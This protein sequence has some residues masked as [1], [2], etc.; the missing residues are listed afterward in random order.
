MLLAGWIWCLAGHLL[1]RG[2]AVTLPRVAGICPNEVNPNLWVDAMSTCTRECQSDQECESLEKCCAN[3]C[4]SRSCVA[5]RYADSAGARGPSGEPKGGTCD[6]LKCAQQGSQCEVWDGQPAC[7]CQERC[8]REPSFTCASDGMTYYNRCYMDAEACSKGIALSEVTCR[9][10]WPNTSP[11]TDGTTARPTV[12]LRPTTPAAIRPPA[13][14]VTAARQA[15]FVGDTA[16]FLCEEAGRLKVEITWEKH[17]PNRKNVAMKPNRI[18]GNAVVTNVGQLV[19]Y[20]VQ[21]EDAGAYTCTATD[22]AGSTQTHFTLSVVQREPEKKEAESNATRFQAEDCLVPPD[23]EDCGEE[24]SSWHYDGRRDDC[25]TF[26]DGTCSKSRNRFDSYEICMLSCHPE[27]VA[28]CALPRQ[29]GPCKAYEPRWAF[30]AA[31]RQ[32]QPFVYGGCGG[33]E[34]NFETKEACEDAC[35]YPRSQRCK[36]C[37]PRHRMVSSFCRADFAILARVTEVTEVTEERD[38]GHMVVT[39]D[40]ILKDEKMGLRFFGKEPLEIALQNVDWTCPCPGVSGG[41]GQVIIMGHVTKGMATLQPDSFVSAYSARRVRKLR[42]VTS[43]GTCD[44]L[45]EFAP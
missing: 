16:S 27:P 45:K 30:S 12:A 32:C 43:K 2:A 21:P 31:A 26:A 11:L 8:G 18:Y 36:P 37:R 19:V 33:N 34:N 4:G 23:A 42:E 25:F 39:V 6:T 5:A 13:P 40:E 3:V 35:P 22:A 20:D 29:Q 9:F 10:T 14:Q 41:D 1:V 7:R 17:G 24:K 44:I 38:S 28:P 15:V